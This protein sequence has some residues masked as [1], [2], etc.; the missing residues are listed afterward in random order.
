MTA[1]LSSYYGLLPGGTDQGFPLLTAAYQNG[2]AGG[3]QGYQRFWDQF[4]GVRVSDIAA[5][6][7]GRVTAT[8]TYTFKDG[9]VQRERT[10]FVM[11]VDGG[12][13][14]IDSSTVVG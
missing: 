9:R 11:V 3:R 2:K 12:I 14:K 1:A 5:V 7:P 4:S 10:V 8:I 13:L 6:V